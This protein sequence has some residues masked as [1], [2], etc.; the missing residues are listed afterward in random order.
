LS[1]I[2]FSGDDRSIKSRS[3]CFE[4]GPNF[5][6]DSPDNVCFDQPER[7]HLKIAHCED[8]RVRP[9]AITSQRFGYGTYPFESDS[10]IRRSRFPGRPEALHLA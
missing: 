3:G 9:E 8:Y 10:S 2:R 7:L 1:T 4:P 5:L 6:S